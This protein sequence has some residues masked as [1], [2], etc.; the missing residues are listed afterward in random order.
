M[1]KRTFGFYAITLKRMRWYFHLGIPVFRTSSAKRVKIER[2]KSITPALTDFHK[3]ILHN[4]IVFIPDPA[5]LNLR[6][7][8]CHKRSV[9]T[10]KIDAG[11]DILNSIFYLACFASAARV[12]KSY[13]PRASARAGGDM[14]NFCDTFGLTK[15][16]RTKDANTVVNNKTNIRM[17]I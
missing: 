1:T 5:C 13:Q 2:H 12:V 7:V 14:F 15:I 10:K 17:D 3:N 16:A 4:L 9:E 11:R 6:P 8:A